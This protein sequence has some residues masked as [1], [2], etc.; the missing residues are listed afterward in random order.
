MPYPMGL[1]APED[2]AAVERM[3]AALAKDMN[4]PVPQARVFNSG[5]IAT[6]TATLKIL[7]FDTEV[8]DNGSVHSTSA[9]TSRLTAP[10]TGAYL[11]G[12]C[13]QWASNAVGVRQLDLLVTNAGGTVRVESD[14]RGAVNGD[15]TQQTVTTLFQMAATDYVEAQV[16]QNSGGAL[17]VLASAVFSPVLW[18]VRLGG[19][20]NQGV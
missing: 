13:V 1:I 17:N 2:W 9:N 3:R 6:V 14:E 5:N 12:A 7:T 4:P 20:V 16:F 19:Y 15:T 10:I 18:M 8:F 11:M